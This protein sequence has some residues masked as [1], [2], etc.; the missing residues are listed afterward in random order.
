MPGIQE[1]RAALIT[2]FFDR[3][4]NN[5]ISTESFLLKLANLTSTNIAQIFGLTSKGEIREGK[6][7]DLVIIDVEKRNIIKQDMLFSKCG[8]SPYDGRFLRGMPDLTILRGQTV[9]S[10]GR[11]NEEPL[12]RIVSK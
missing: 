7:A 3:G 5:S 9:Y 1:A 12:G 6:D 4:L 8:W 10:Y 11:I 2:G